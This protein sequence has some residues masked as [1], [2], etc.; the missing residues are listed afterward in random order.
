MN[1][2]KKRSVF[3]THKHY[4]LSGAREMLLKIP[5]FLGNSNALNTS[6]LLE[7]FLTSLRRAG[8]VVSIATRQ[9]QPASFARGSGV[10]SRT[11]VARRS[12]R[13]SRSLLAV[14]TFWP[15]RAMGACRTRRSQG[16]P[17]SRRTSNADHTIWT[18]KTT[19]PRN[20]VPARVARFALRPEQS[21]SSG[22]PGTPDGSRSAFDALQS[23]KF[24]NATTKG[25]HSFWHTCGPAGPAT[26][27][28]PLGPGGHT[29]QEATT[30][31][32]E[33]AWSW[34]TLPGGPLAPG[35]PACPSALQADTRGEFYPNDRH[36]LTPQL[37]GRRVLRADREDNPKHFY[38]LKD[39][40]RVF[41]KYLSHP[42]NFWGSFRS[43]LSK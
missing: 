3:G 22:E 4:I 29:R 7:S 30:A 15:H 9:S 23:P 2:L 42:S 32:D 39:V 13:T 21:G 28:G 5:K 17:G 18:G 6:A 24:E 12:T 35:F 41:R 8:A 33:T 11:H 31:Y 20:A 34:Y 1:C 26:P 43:Y 19:T 38:I 36:F 10:T 37:Q 14:A 40:L 27:L 16:T 25:K